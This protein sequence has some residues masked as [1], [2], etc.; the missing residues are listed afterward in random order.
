[1]RG[2]RHPVPT[3]H[4]PPAHVN[5]IPGQ[6]TVVLVEPERPL[7]IGAAARAMKNAGVTRLALV[8]P[9]PKRLDGAYRMATNAT[10]VLD[11]A[12]TCDSLAD[13]IGPAVTAFA[14][15]RRGDLGDPGVLTPRGLGELL[16]A[17][18]A[19][20]PAALVFGPEHRGLSNGE[21]GQCHRVVTI[22]SSPD[23]PSL[24]LSH[25]VMVVCLELFCARFT[26]PAAPA[27]DAE[28]PPA[29][30]EVEAVL[31]HARETLLT[32]GFLKP[33]NP[34]RLQPLFRSLIARAR[35]SAR[36]LRVLRGILA[37]IDWAAGSRRPFGEGTGFG[38]G[39]SPGT[40]GSTPARPAGPD[41]A[42]AL[43]SGLLPSD[44]ANRKG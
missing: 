4:H 7:N 28:P 30:G 44:A 38:S 23:C 35:V 42:T 29:A 19:V 5:P 17:D 9:V 24:N 25:A 12:R 39:P 11:N 37:Q 15:T 22:P 31:A 43:P 20:L 40:D 3:A 2:E 18:P 32:I 41:G 26:R 27:R 13:A 33:Q 8:R 1:M 14:V 16:V 6:I 36:E 10:D 34:H 21:I